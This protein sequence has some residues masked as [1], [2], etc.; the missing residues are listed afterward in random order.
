MPATDLSFEISRFSTDTHGGIDV[1][2]HDETEAAFSEA[3]GHT[4][5]IARL[6]EDAADEFIA[7]LPAD[8]RAAFEDGEE[9]L[10]VASADAEPLLAV[11]ARRLSRW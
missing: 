9:V 3:A 8:V 4:I 5:G 1:F 11:I 7:A 10:V 6:C 2:A